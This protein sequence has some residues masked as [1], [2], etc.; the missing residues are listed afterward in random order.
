MKTN[1]YAVKL[2]GANKQCRFSNMH[3]TQVKRFLENNGHQV[4][5]DPKDADYILSYFTRVALLI[6]SKKKALIFIVST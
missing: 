4:T 2:S 5:K 6:N 1:P 3:L